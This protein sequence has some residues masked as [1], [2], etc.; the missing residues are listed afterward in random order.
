MV[1]LILSSNSPPFAADR[2]PPSARRTAPP[3]SAPALCAFPGDRFRR[4]CMLS[5]A[6]LRYACASLQQGG[7]RPERRSLLTCVSVPFAREEKRRPVVFEGHEGKAAR[8]GA[9]RSRREVT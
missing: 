9:R 8:R 4:T 3:S 6:A 1:P 2:Q 7:S 5:A